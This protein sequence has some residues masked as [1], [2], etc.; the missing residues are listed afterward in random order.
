[1]NCGEG[2]NKRLIKVKKEI[3]VHSCSF[4]AEIL[5]LEIYRYFAMIS[6]VRAA[7]P[8]FSSIAR[9]AFEPSVSA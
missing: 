9:R 5:P 4:V 1:M 8:R 7:A 6:T 2:R 3:C